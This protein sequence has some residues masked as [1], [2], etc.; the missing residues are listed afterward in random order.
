MFLVISDISI[1]SALRITQN[2]NDRVGIT[3]DVEQ[4]DET[5][6]QKLV[7]TLWFCSLWVEWDLKNLEISIHKNE[8]D[9]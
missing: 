1:I 5:N 8:L 7:G 6:V 4:N 3:R 2:C 9:L